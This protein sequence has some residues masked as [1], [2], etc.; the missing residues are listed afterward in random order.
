MSSVPTEFFLVYPDPTLETGWDGHRADLM[1]RSRSKKFTGY[2][3][4]TFIFLEC[5]SRA[6]LLHQ[7]KEKYPGVLILELV[8]TGFGIVGE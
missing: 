6:G 5:Q 1:K 8:P 3:R 2:R 4:S 7:I